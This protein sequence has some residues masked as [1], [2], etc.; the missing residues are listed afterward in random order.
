MSRDAESRVKTGGK[1]ERTRAALVAAALEV[2]S[3]RGFAAASL[4]EIAARAGMTKGAIYSNFSGKAELLLAAMSAKG[5]TLASDRPAASTIGEELEAMAGD[6][7]ATLH[8]ATG[9]AGFLAEF[10]LYALSDPEIRK[11]LAAAYADGFTGTAAYLARLRDVRPDI[12][13]RRLAVAL[14][15]VAIGFVVQSL[16]TPDEVTDAVVHETLKALAEGLTRRPD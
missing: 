15:A 16:I 11:G 4:D 10:Q 6:L 12:T 8:R 5:L 13:P 3:E 9:E 14:Q 1:R 2:V 7:A